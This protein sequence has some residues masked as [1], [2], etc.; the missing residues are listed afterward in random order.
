M[1]RQFDGRLL[2]DMHAE[3]DRGIYVTHVD[4]LQIDR[5]SPIRQRTA[6]LSNVVDADC[7]LLLQ[8]VEY[9]LFPTSFYARRRDAYAA[10]HT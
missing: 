10:Y 4:K 1:K 5:C 9:Q 2:R 8:I 3:D 6:L 7:L